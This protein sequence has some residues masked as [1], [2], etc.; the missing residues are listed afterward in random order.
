LLGQGAP[1][2][3]LH[4]FGTAALGVVVLAA[5]TEGWLNGPLAMSLRVALFGA[6]L[7]LI[8]PEPISDAVGLALAFGIWAWQ[9]KIHGADPGAKIAPPETTRA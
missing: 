3:M 9:R 4:N 6:A 2:D 1:L 5:S 7:C 8:T